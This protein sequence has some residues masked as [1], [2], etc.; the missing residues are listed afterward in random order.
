M[1]QYPYMV[2]G[3]MKKNDSITFSCPMFFSDRRL[4]KSLRSNSYMIAKKKKRYVSNSKINIDFN[5]IF[6]FILMLI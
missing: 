5:S 6:I 4:S 1:L 2:L 3:N